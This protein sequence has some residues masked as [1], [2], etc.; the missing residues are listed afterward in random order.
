MLACCVLPTCAA[1]A[2]VNLGLK[3][4]VGLAKVAFVNFPDHL[5]DEDTDFRFA[6]LGGITFNNSLTEAYLHKLSYNLNKT[7]KIKLLT[8]KP[9]NK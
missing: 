8:I 7:K 3:A 5:N 1:F 6:Y 4:G 2:Q 9:L